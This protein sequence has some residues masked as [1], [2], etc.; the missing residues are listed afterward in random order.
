VLG[1]RSRV[2]RPIRRAPDFSLVLWAAYLLCSVNDAVNVLPC[3]TWSYLNGRLSGA[4]LPF[5]D[6]AGF[7][8]AARLRIWR[9]GA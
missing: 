1:Q 5:Q 4:G 3:S 7:P 2:G 6:D 8:A 9:R